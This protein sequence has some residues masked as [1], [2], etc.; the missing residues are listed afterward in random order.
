MKNATLSL[1]GYIRTPMVV[2][3]TRKRFARYSDVQLTSILN[4]DPPKT[5]KDRAQDLFK[6]Y[7]GF[8]QDELKSR[9]S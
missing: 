1:D 3:M 4:L 9:K 5:N 8:A 7:L 2:E 6:E